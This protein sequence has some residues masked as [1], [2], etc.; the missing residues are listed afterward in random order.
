MVRDVGTPNGEQ[1][2]RGEAGMAGGRE[3]LGECQ[4]EASRGHMRHSLPPVVVHTNVHAY[5]NVHT[6]R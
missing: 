1:R 4:K 5:I 3:G 2:E 6:F